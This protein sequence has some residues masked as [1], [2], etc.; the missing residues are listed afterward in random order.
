MLQIIIRPS[1]MMVLSSYVVPATVEIDG[2]P[3]TPYVTSLV[4]ESQRN[5]ILLASWLIG[6]PFEQLSYLDK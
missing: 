6:Y 4:K 3:M 5:Y 2:L 1:L